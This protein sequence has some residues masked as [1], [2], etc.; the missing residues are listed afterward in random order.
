MYPV[1]VPEKISSLDYIF[2]VA[3]VRALEKS[4]LRQESFDRAIEASLPEALRLFVESGRYDDELLQVRQSRQLEMLL[5]RQQQ[6]LEQ[7]VRSLLP[8]RD[9]AALVQLSD[10]TASADLLPRLRNLFVQDYLLHLIDLHNIKT[11]LR[12]SILQEPPEKLALALT[13]EG[14]IPKN[15]LVRLY[16]QDVAVLLH[17]LEYVHK[18]QMIVDYTAFLGEAIRQL[19][20]T[21]SFAKLEKAIQ[22]FLISLLKPA[23]YVTFGPEPVVAYYFAKRNEINLIRMIVLAKLNDVSPATVRERL[24]SVYA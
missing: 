18:R 6:Q 11:F 21:R 23:K 22:D 20:K 5:A 4:L 16:G 3:R 7:F 12:L 17:R 24:N 2:A 13:A 10:L 14:F 8:E 19:E 1:G 15:E 9:L